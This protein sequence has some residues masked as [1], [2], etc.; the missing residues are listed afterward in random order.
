MPA[1]T[2]YPDWGTDETNNVEP[3]AGKIAEGW[4]PAEQP[5]AG[6][7][8]WWKN[9]VGLWTRWLESEVIAVKVR[10]DDAEDDIDGL[11]DAL[12]T[13]D[14]D[15]STLEG[16]AALKASQN[17][18]TKSQIINSESNWADDPLVST[19]A[20][21]GD[22]PTDL[23]GVPAAAGSNRW[24][25]IIAAPTQGTAYGGIFIGQSP[26]GAA[27]VNNARWHIPT[28]KWRQIDPA[29]ASTAIVG[30]SGQWVASYTPAGS[31]PWTDWPTDSGGDFLAGG[32]IASHG[33]F[34]YHPPRVS[35][36][37]TI[38]LSCSSGEAILQS[39]DG[40]YKLGPDGACWALKVPD[41]TVLGDIYVVVDQASAFG[42]YVAL[43]RRDKG[44]SSTFPTFQ[45]ID[46]NNGPAATGIQQIAL[47]TSGH[48]AESASWEY[49]VMVKRVHADDKVGRISMSVFTDTGPRNLG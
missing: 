46:D 15:L 42:M 4:L 34:L 12:T 20:K 8:N 40:S 3:P 10:V 39:T 21:P 28:Q 19:T 14:T 41:L 44:S 30:R 23:S 13:L 31:V 48:S 1:P 47:A 9:L 35:T 18:F 11:S 16:A 43:V 29:Y 37:V 6:W 45:T 38:P 22:D 33:L 17:T 7:F 36:D 25:L 5:P 2:N 32:N 24:K 27:M 49:S 26:D